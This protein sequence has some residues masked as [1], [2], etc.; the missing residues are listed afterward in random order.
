MQFIGHVVGRSYQAKILLFVIYFF[1]H[2][3]IFL[4][5]DT[6]FWDDWVIYGN[7]SSA[8]F[9]TFAQAGAILNW[10]AY[11]HIALLSLGV[12]VYK[13]LTFFLMFFTGLLYQEIA[14]RTGAF[15][16]TYVYIST[17]LFLILPLFSSRL[18]LIVFP[19]TLCY[20]LFFLGWWLMGKNKFMSITLFFL[21]FNINSML[22]FYALPMLDL[23]YRNQVLM[24]PTKWPGFIR[25]NFLFLFLP[26]VF[27]AVKTQFEPYGSYAG[28][29]QQF[30]LLGI[31]EAA[32]LQYADLFTLRFNPFGFVAVL[33]ASLAFHLLY[34]R[35][36]VRGIHD[37]D[38]DK[39][40]AWGF[41][42]GVFALLCALFPYWI[43][44]HVPTFYEWTSRH[45]LLMPLGVS[46]VL[47]SL[48]FCLGSSVRMFLTST[49]VAISITF[50][51]ENY[52]DF[53]RDSN[54][55]E[56]IVHVFSNNQLLKA[57]NVAVFEDRTAD[58]N[59]IGREYRFYEWHGFMNAAFGD[60]SR[61]ALS[62]GQLPDYQTGV[63]DTRF[64]DIN[65]AGSHI[66]KDSPKVVLVVLTLDERNSTFLHPK[67]RL[68][69]VPLDI[70]KDKSADRT[71]NI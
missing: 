20:F 56:E 51:I 27:F 31:S 58:L 10:T 18:A 41:L 63:L 42:I 64:L 4:L 14:V 36:T 46:L 1:A 44:G 43:L 23:A 53:L 57:S 50:W 26:F 40:S 59:A 48:I 38:L 71:R 54:K 12:W 39:F 68:E 37:L 47:T 32:G 34:R 61:F 65:M 45:Q 60:Q 28:Y 67:L 9:D 3:W 25:D 49:L 19:Y 52:I 30:S 35:F 29:N 6:V 8:I 62:P 2:A 21:S 22:V 16:K 70:G 69:V 55:Q 17:L 7:T 33:A 5:L 11:L 24:S 66:R 13:L 15:S